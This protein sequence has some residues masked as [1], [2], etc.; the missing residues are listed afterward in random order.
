MKNSLKLVAIAL[1]CATVYT[2]CSSSEAKKGVGVDVANFDS[3][4]AASN[5]FFHFANGGWI[6]KN[7]IPA[8]Q[9]RSGTFPNLI[10]N[11]RKNLHQLV[12][13]ASA[14]TDSKKGSPEQLVGDMYFSAMDTVT[15][16][17]LGAEPIR[18][19]MEKIDKLTDLNSILSYTAL[20]Q[21]WGASPM[22][23]LYA[24]QDPKNGEVVVRQIYQGGLSLPDRDFYVNNDERSTK[25]R[26]EFLSHMISMFKLYGLDEATATKYANV[27]MRIETNLAKASMTRVEQRDPYKTYNKVTIADLNAMTPSLRWDEMMKNLDING[28]YDYLVLGQPLFLKELENQLK[29]NSIDDWKIYLKWNL[30]NLAGNVLSN[31]FVNQDFYFNNKVLNGQKEIQSRWKRMVQITDGMVGDAL[32]QLYVAKFFPPESKK[33]MDELVSNLIVVYNERIDKLDWMSA[34]TKVKAKEKLNAITRKIGY[35]D[36]WKDYAGLD[37]NRGSFFKNLMNATKWNYEYAISQIGKPVDRS[38]WGMTPPTVNAYYNPSLNEIVF[39]A[40]ILQP[41]FF[42]AQA[43]DAVNYGAI[44]AVIGHEL[45]HGFDDEG[46]NFDAKGNLN[47][48]WTSEDSAKFVTRAQV[49][50]DQFDGF[51]VLDT[52]HVNGHLT[53]GENIADLGGVTIAYDAFK[54]TKQGQGKE[55][56][57]GMT[58]DQR[59]FFGFATIWAGSMRPEAAAQRIITDPHSPGL[60]RVNGPLSNL[61]EFYKAFGVKEA[62]KM[63]RPDSIRAKIW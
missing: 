2:S 29:S 45:T 51:T 37:I 5:D 38:Q 52:L 49:I 42:N 9:V 33:K 20:L 14:K 13:E 53:L 1:G 41:P 15:I 25:I 34:A 59:F 19:E 63:Y 18:P 47:A 46:R 4:V 12:D 10:E 44:G 6:K 58:P 36:K 35:P 27:V 28:G 7:P 22:Y 3:T 8:D 30:L 23:G 26:T 60:Y 54:R 55:L 40:G 48:W 24:G 32:G 50:I 61:E 39:P 56:I 31:D 43:D 17:K 57:D 16:E 11:N 21:K 62:D